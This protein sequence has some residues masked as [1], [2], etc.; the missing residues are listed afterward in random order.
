MGPGKMSTLMTL[1]ECI[2]GSTEVSKVHYYPNILTLI[3]WIL[4]FSSGLMPKDSGKLTNKGFAG[5][6]SLIRE[7]R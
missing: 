3:N 5:Q 2:S 7:A 4:T 1:K 6:L